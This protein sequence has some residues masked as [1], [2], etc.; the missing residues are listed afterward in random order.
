MTKVNYAI[1]A[2]AIVVIIVAI[3][4]YQFYQSISPNPIEHWQASNEQNKQ[5]IDHHLWEVFLAKH[6]HE[7]V[8]KGIYQFDYDK[9]TAL[10]KKNLSQYLEHLQGIDPRVYRKNV[11]LAYWAN[12]YNALTIDIVL[13][14][15]PI[16]SI[17]DIGNGITGPWNMKLI[18]IAGQPLTLNEIEHGILRALWQDNRIHYVINC[19][20]VGCPDLPKY[21]LVGKN[22]E[23]QLEQA[24]KRFIN[25]TKGVEFVGDKLIISSIYNWFKKDFANNDSELLSHLSQYA[26]AELKT[27]LMSYQGDID[28]QYNWELNGIN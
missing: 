6:L 14:H 22:I 11:Q 21:A 1:I 18:N 19:A 7:N 3:K 24:A 15:Y 27:Q 9:V 20:S 8:S 10:D 5:S 26:N 17:K 2:L 12:L 25:Q 4:G 13:K 28:Y 16:E 23:Q